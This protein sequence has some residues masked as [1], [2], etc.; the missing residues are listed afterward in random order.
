MTDLTK[1]VQ[2]RDGRKARVICTDRVGEFPVVALVASKEEESIYAYTAEGRY[3]ADVQES[4][5]D[6]FNIPDLMAEAVGIINEVR[7]YLVDGGYLGQE[8]GL[9]W[10]C[11][12][13]LAQHKGSE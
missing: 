11:D 6:L 1:P 7:E 4:P 13:F 5:S 3:Y 9:K 2:T 8:D 12:Q 10:Q